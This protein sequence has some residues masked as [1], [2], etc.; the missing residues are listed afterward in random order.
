MANKIRI[1]RRAAGGAAG[2][3]TSLENAELAFN[4][5]DV[6][7]YY[8]TGTGGAGGTATSIIPIAG[9]GAFVDKTTAQT[10]AGTKTF[11]STISGS[12]S[13]N[14]GTA[15]ALQTARNI[16]VSGDISGT[17]S[18]DGTANISIAS[19]LATVNSNIGTFTKITTNAKGLVT[20]AATASL[21]DIT[22]PTADYSFGGFKLTNLAEPSSAQ[23]ATTKNYVDNA[24]QGLDAKPSVK[25]ATTANIALTATQ[26]I[27]GIALAVND[28][29]LVK[30][31][32]AP[33]ENG[34]YVVSASAWTRALDI[35]TWLE[36][37]NAFTFVEEGT[38]Q[39]DTSWVC[40]SNQAG[41]IG[42]TAITFVQFGAASSY[43]AGNGLLLTGNSF[44]VVGT[45]NRIS[46]GSSVDIAATYVGQ[47]SITTL[48]TVSA[49]T[50]NGTTIT[51]PFGGT[52]VATLTGLVK[53][54]GAA[55]FSAAVDGTDYL[56]PNAII[57]GG[58]F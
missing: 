33:A 9:A 46:V 11:S 50:W 6:T 54:N 38:T 43:T 31:Q 5:Q 22:S 1:K 52:G 25:A 4:E 28:R 30:N 58:T 8:G 48:G 19:T 16:A 27:D 57:D 47:T 53:G 18:F 26:T 45:A 56:S 51:V 35:N 42:T 39:A 13:G 40:T 29:V 37:P 55:A 34:I 41:T 10:I 15:T 23:D 7:L 20:A 36:V 21:S 49:G 12:V 44:S 3:P 2:A 14:A 24:V 17:S 32:T